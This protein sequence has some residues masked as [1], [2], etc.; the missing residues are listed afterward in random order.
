MSLR[1][2]LAPMIALALSLSAC[3]S[4]G[5]PNASPTEPSQQPT[6]TIDP[7]LIPSASPT[8]LVPSDP[9][10]F[11]SATGD[12]VFKVSDGGAWCTIVSDASQ[13]ICE[14]SEAAAQYQPV[15]TPSDCAYSFGYQ[16]A[17]QANRPEAADSAAFVCAGGYY[18]DPAGAAQ[19]QSGESIAVG[20]FTCFV[21][22]VTA[23]CENLEGN[24]IVLGPKAWALGN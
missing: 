10:L 14:I 21:Q 17:L 5:E 8:A 16:I 11:M 23:R 9:A 6:S 1:I 12:Y 4:P 13:A 22:D 19:L 7:T 18:S 20:D 15:E 24:Y 3:S 2:L